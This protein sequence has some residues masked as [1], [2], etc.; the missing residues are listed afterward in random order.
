MREGP[1]QHKSPK[2]FK[3]PP[4]KYQPRGL[5]VLY[6]DVDILVVNKAS[7]LATISNDSA[8]ERT[9]YFLLTDYVRKGNVKS[10]K[11]VFIV[12]RLDRDTSGVLVLAKH[13][14]AKRYLQDNWSDFKKTY[15]AVVHGRPPEREGVIRSYLAESETYRVY[16]VSDPQGGKLAKTAYRMVRQTPSHALLEINLLTGRKN[17]I[18]V[19]LADKGCPVVGDAKYGRKEPG[20][21]RLALHAMSMT[22][23][24]PHTKQPMTFDAPVPAYMKTLIK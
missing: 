8:R 12:H 3:R 20:I 6:E 9:A 11:R 4:R 19:H 15:C 23:N 21:R 14:A 13:E 1:T 7:G 22:I 2:P 16:S 24:H 5:P 10:Q 18:R 17:Q